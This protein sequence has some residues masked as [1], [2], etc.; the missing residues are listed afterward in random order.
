MAD[1][2]HERDNISAF[3]D[4]KLKCFQV[5]ST[6]NLFLKNILGF[7]VNLKVTVAVSVLFYILTHF[8]MNYFYHR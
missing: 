8:S 1:N 4:L 5:L 7:E 6:E 3:T 2:K